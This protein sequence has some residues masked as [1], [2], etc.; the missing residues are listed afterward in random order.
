[1]EEENG[2]DFQ[3]NIIDMSGRKSWNKNFGGSVHC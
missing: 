3:R 2:I 1:M